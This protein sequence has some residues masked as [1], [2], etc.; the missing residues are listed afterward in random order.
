MVTKIAVAVALAAFLAVP[1][2][3]FAASK[4]SESD[5]QS[6]STQR[7]PYTPD[8]VTRQHGANRD[9]QGGGGRYYKR[10]KTKRHHSH[11]PANS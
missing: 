9:F 1:S 6:Q 3:S 11:S 10:S 5:Q 8:I 2:A 7:G 4:K